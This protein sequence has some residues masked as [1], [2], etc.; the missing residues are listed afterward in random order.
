VKHWQAELE[1]RQQASLYRSRRVLD[2][3]QGVN[4]TI[5]NKTYLSFCSNDYLGLANHPLV[6]EALQTGA[7][8]YGVGSGA[9]HL[10]T[11]HST[12]HHLL[13]Q[14][15]AEFTGRER[16]LLFSTGYM[17]NVGVI[18]A[19]AGRNDRIFADR[20]NHASLVDGAL[21]SHAKLRRYRHSDTEQLRDWLQNDT[22]N[23]PSTT[24]VVTDGIFSMDGDIAPL[25]KLNTLCTNSNAI[26]MVDDAHGFGVLGEHGGGCCEHFSLHNDTVPV[27]VGTLGKALGTFGAFVAGSE[28][29]IEYLIQTARTYVYTTALPPAVAHAT[30]TSLRL[31]REEPWRR[32]QLKQLVAYFRREAVHL[33]ITLGDTQT[34]IQPL[35][36]GDAQR[37]VTLA[38]QLKERGILIPAIRPP[39]VPNGSARLR[40]T[41]SA[42][43]QLADVTRLLETLKE[44][45]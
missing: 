24:L 34:P 43:H 15:L 19:L 20:L 26:L 8:R 29:L 6:V 31:A 33:P 27:L 4:V 41:F 10:V 30:R 7:T 13:E 38:E 35:I 3:P 16:A 14:E 42:N 32:D 5:D 45:L 44:L 22:A 37:A 21:L 40:I 39:T 11:G 23:E 2:G 18:S 36:V 17:A 9:A 28:T 12:P 25:P 1:R